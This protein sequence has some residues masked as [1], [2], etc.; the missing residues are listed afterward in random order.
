MAGRSVLILPIDIMVII[1]IANINYLY[2]VLA[3]YQQDL[4]KKL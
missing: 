1:P 2:T 4:K 3:N